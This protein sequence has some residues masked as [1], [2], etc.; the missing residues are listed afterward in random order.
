MLPIV[1]LAAMAVYVGAV[2]FIRRFPA[3][4]GHPEQDIKDRSIQDVVYLNN[5]E[6]AVFSSLW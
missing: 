4:G 2:A 1:Y 3:Q 5:L 6:G